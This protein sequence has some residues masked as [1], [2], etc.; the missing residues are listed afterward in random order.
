DG[1]AGLVEA[2]DKSTVGHA[3]LAHGGIDALDP[4]RAEGALFALAVAIG[5]L[6][7]LFDRLFGDPAGVLA[8]A[9]GG[10]GLG[11]GFLMLCVG[12]VV[13]FDACHGDTPSATLRWSGAP[14]GRA[15]RL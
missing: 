15:Q 2:V 14:A 3:V 8:A 7:R 4:Q 9:V 1:N 5:V 13:A 11:N 6:H 12:C 10:R